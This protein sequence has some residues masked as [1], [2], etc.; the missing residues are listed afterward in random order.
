MP[1]SPD[2][3]PLL[4]FGAHPDDIEFGCGGVIAQEVRA[5]R[6]AHLVVCSRGEAASSGTPE[7]RTR[8]AERAAGLLGATVEFLDLGGD[9]HLEATP[10]N[11]LRLAAVIRRVRPAVVLAPTLV[12]N[13]H[14]DHSRVGGMAR[15]ACRL[16]RYGGLAE[17]RSLSPHAVDGLLYYAVTPE[18]EPAGVLPVLVDVSDAATLAAWT[19]AMEAHG[20]QLKT[21]RYVDLQLT[22]ARLLGLRAGVEH[23]VALYPN[24]PLVVT[25]LAAVARA[26]RRF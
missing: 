24:D 11:A 26:A 13:Q 19:A 18:G 23:A 6:A 1:T 12:E 20:S 16:A 9:A 5:G 14:P 10:A 21:R 22:R 4:A 25:G 8:E 17:L 3:P 2:L 15:D 7:E